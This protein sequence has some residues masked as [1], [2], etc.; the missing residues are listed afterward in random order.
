MGSTE[1]NEDDVTRV[2]SATAKLKFG[3]D[4]GDADL[5]GQGEEE[6]RRL[7]EEDTPEG[8]IARAIVQTLDNDNTS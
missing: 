6:L 8:Q 3:S 5:A 2:T 7:A 4:Q 1:R